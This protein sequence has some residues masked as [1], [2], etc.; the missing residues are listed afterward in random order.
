MAL[1][2]ENSFDD[3]IAQAQK[4]CRNNGAR[5]TTLRK[6]ILKLVWQHGKPI[7][8]YALME[9]LEQSSHRDN[10]APPT[11]YRSLDFLLEQGLIR[12][13]HSQNTYVACCSP[14]HKQGDIMFLCDQCGTAIEVLNNSIQQAINLSASQHKFKVQTQVFE[15]KGLCHECKIGAAK[16]K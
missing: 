10:V 16:S 7:G 3:V 6:Q 4:V 11:V 12:K 8:A 9:Q 1:I 15:I 2:A 13:I 5:L 14:I